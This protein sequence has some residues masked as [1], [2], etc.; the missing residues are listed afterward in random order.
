VYRSRRDHHH[1]SHRRADWQ[2][3]Y[4]AHRI[5]DRPAE[6]PFKD[7]GCDG[8]DRG[9]RCPFPASHPCENVPVVRGPAAKRG[10]DAS[11]CAAPVETE[12]SG[13]HGKLN[14]I[15]VER[16]L[17]DLMADEG[18]GRV[19]HAG[20]GYPQKRSGDDEDQPGARQHGDT[21][22]DPARHSV[23]VVRSARQDRRGWH[24]RRGQRCSCRLGRR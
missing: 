13:A 7:K 24:S 20:G 8:R 4:R 16:A 3:G 6:S 2:G 21:R 12:A 15:E 18:T 19:H 9:N 11:E 10:N 23:I 14:P 5:R 17:R 1:E 22:S